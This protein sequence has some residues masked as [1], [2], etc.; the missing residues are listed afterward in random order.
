MMIEKWMG[1]SWSVRSGRQ[2]DDVHATTGWAVLCA[3]NSGSPAIMARVLPLAAGEERANLLELLLD[4]K[5]NWTHERK[6][7]RLMKIKPVNPQNWWSHHGRI[8]VVRLGLFV[9]LHVCQCK[10]KVALGPFLGRRRGL[11][12]LKTSAWWAASHFGCGKRQLTWWSPYQSPLH[13][14]P[15]NWISM[16]TT[17]DHS[18]Y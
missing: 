9:I 3:F 16:P 2:R 13:A 11:T 7:S 12:T 10:C 5:K 6:S 1:V 17:T 15:S 14:P 4:I 8:A 18:Y